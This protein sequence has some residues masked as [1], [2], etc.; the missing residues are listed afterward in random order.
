MQ[1][2]IGTENERGASNAGRKIIMESNGT[3][4]EVSIY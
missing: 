2:Y 1:T 3:C 4:T